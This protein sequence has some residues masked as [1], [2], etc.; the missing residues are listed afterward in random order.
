MNRAPIVFTQRAVRLV[1]AALGVTLAVILLLVPAGGS[2]TAAD[3][4]WLGLEGDEA[5]VAAPCPAASTAPLV[6]VSP[7]RLA[8][9]RAGSFR[10]FGPKP[11]ELAPPVDWTRDPLGARRYR[12]NLQKLRFLAPLLTSYANDGNTEDL[13]QALALALDWVEENP[14]SGQGTP[15]EAWSD[16][17]VGDRSPYLSYLTRAAACEGLATP[18]EREV[19]IT[20]LEKHGRV[21]ANEESYIADNHGLFVDLGLLRLS[22]FFPY[23]GEAQGWR[24]LA[25]ERFESTLRGRLAEGV[26]LEHSSA[27]QFLAVRP[28]ED[29]LLDFGADPE[30]DGVLAEMKAASAWFLRPDGEMTQFG[31]SNL[32]RVPDWATTA[33]TDLSGMRVFFEAGFAFVRGT[34]ADGEPGYLAI[35]DGFHNLTHKHADELSFELFDRGVSIVNDTGL[36]HKD[37]G[38]VRD[39]VVSNRAHSTLTADGLDWPIADNSRSYGSGLVAAGEGEGWYAIEGRNPLLKP[40]GIK[41]RRLFLYRPGSALLIVDRVQSEATHTLNRYLHLGPD[42]EIDAGASDVLELSA[43]GLSGA[44]RDLAEPGATVTRTETRGQKVPLQGLTSPDFREFV[45]RWSVVY[46][47]PA[48]D[49]LR[50]LSISLDESDL[51]ASAAASDG[52]GFTLELSDASGTVTPLA[53]AQ[54]GAELT[55]TSP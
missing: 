19:L 24:A 46:T 42:V 38:E 32:E 10:V 17:V 53:V 49:A 25:R 41:H 1:E 44:V 16:K 14:R 52:G 9:A 55:V 5:L 6:K 54:S 27:Y 11:T 18:A 48:A 4:R 26:W 34:G 50:V 30:L 28:L 35:G 8:A 31:D 37:P 12:Q 43:P 3:E 15:A 21:L 51:H 7:S 13:E 22:N 47:E 23:L 29:F 45:P 2:G 33:A 20:A 36:Y 40:Q 39:Y